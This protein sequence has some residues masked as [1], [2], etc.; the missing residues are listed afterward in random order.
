MDCYITHCIA[1]YI[2]IDEDKNI[3]DYLFFDDS[4]RNARLKDIE[5]KNILD[6][7]IELIERLYNKYDSI[8]IESN[9]RK[10]NYAKWENVIVEVPNKAGDFL[11]ENLENILIEL[12]FSDRENLKSK[13]T[14]IYEEFALFKVKELSKSEDKYLI[15]AINSIDDI[16]ESIS[17]LIE[18]IREWY[19]LNIP[20]LDT[21][22]NNEKY[23]KLIALNKTKKDIVKEYG[24]ELL[25]NDLED[26]ISSEDLDILNEFANSIY[27]L[28][29]TR[30]NIEKY[31]DLK[32]DSIAPNLKSLVGASLGSKLISHA[33]GLKRLASYPSGTVQIMGA[34]KALFRHLKTGERPPK[35]GLIYQHPQVRTSKW[36]N[37]GKIA[38]TLALKISLAS[39]K[40]FYSKEFDK[41]I[42]EDFLLKVNQIEKDNPFP[43]RSSSTRAKDKK[44]S[45]NKK[46]RKRRK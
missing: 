13:F 44:N 8:S 23:I 39:R 21:I 6:E 7:E 9:S 31:I 46:S 2:A 34:E 14:K 27:S 3:V 32:M 33:G 26:D 15:Q 20:E 11:R 24:D 45:S 12:D 1:G 18:R 38:R 28:Q 17:K 40:D 35:H 41:S 25:F 16:D 22:Q 42:N 10:S 5:D 30:K 43:K 4:N 19:S 37:R 29:K 36:W